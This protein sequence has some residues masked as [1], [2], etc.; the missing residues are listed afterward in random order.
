M[1]ILKK[2]RFALNRRGAFTIEG[3]VKL[4]L[5]VLFTSGIVQSM[6]VFLDALKESSYAIIISIL[7]YLVFTFVG[8]QFLNYYYWGN[9]PYV[10]LIIYIVSAE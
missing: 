10:F 1:K 4:L 7:Y 9:L 3:R 6:P 5:K 8:G 2:L